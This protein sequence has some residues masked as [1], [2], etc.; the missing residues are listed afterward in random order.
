MQRIARLGPHDPGKIEA[1]FRRPEAP[2]SQRYRSAKMI[3]IGVTTLPFRYLRRAFRLHN[4]RG[5]GK[6][7]AV[8]QSAWEKY[9]VFYF[10]HEH[11][12]TIEVI[13]ADQNANGIAF[14][15]IR[16]EKDG[17]VMVVKRRYHEFKELVQTAKECG[18]TAA[19][20][21]GNWSSTSFY[22]KKLTPEE[23]EQRR[24]QLQSFLSACVV[25]GLSSDLSENP[26]TKKVSEV[27]ISR[28]C[29]SHI[30]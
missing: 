16:M 6:T 17:K 1:N 26:G 25:C 14:Y 19:F 8:A 9:A 5:S 24:T 7:N 2:R 29:S 23:L 21:P 22:Y 20:P 11:S 12:E 15:N 30:M 18:V 3:P 4:K 28:L 10:R 13:S 27:N